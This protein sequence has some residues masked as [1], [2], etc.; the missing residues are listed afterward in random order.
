MFVKKSWDFGGVKDC[1]TGPEAIDIGRDDGLENERGNNAKVGKAGASQCTIKL[2]MILLVD[3]GDASVGENDL[4]SSNV[5][6]PPAV[7]V[8]EKADATL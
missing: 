8:R 5:V 4:E 2:G 7:F 6:T 1:Y 3:I